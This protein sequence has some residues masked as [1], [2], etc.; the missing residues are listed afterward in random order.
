MKEKEGAEEKRMDKE[1]GGGSGK[2]E[3]EEE[4]KMKKEKKQWFPI[5]F[6]FLLVLFFNN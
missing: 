2:G 1:E 3:R 6:P 4:E 5:V